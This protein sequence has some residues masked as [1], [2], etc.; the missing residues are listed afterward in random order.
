MNG[1]TYNLRTQDVKRQWIVL[2][3]A[4]EPIGRMS[5]TIATRLI[6]KY[7][8]KF[9]PH[10]D[11]GDHVIIINAE[12]LV[13]TGK[14]EDQK[15]YYRHSGY[16]GSLKETKLKAAKTKKPE[17][18]IEKAVY[19]MLPKN[20]HRSGRMARLHIYSGSEHPH[21]AQKPTQ[22]GDKK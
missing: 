17:M 16:P 11:S 19:G 1:K 3:A 13:T 8:P 21:E 2:D 14:K 20:K 22:L 18:V 12:K 6:G 7:Q 9:T 4:I 15:T 5:T 10:V